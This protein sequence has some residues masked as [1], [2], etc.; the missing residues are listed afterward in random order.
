MNTPSSAPDVV[1]PTSASST[2][3]L[4]RL[5]ALRPWLGRGLWLLAMLPGASLMGLWSH[6]ALEA[7]VGAY[8][9]PS[10]QALQ[11]SGLV[12]LALWGLV[13]LALAVATRAL[14]RLSPLLGPA[15]RLVTLLLMS[16]VFWTVLCMGVLTAVGLGPHPQLASLGGLLGLVLWLKTTALGIQGLMPRR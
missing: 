2:S 8:G 14:P 3:R 10:M 9:T 12:A 5:G 15:L 13:L 7:G 6:H 11:A 16:G 4:G 1:A